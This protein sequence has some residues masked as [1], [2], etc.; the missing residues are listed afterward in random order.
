MIIRVET[1]ADVPTIRSVVTTAFLDAEHGSGNEAQII[2]ALREDGALSVSLVADDAVDVVGHAAFS[3]VVVGGRDINW[4][5]LGP[6]AVLPNKRRKGVAESLITA[7]LER[8]KK[9]GAEGCVVLGDPH[10]YRRFGFNS[11]PELCFADVPPEYFQRVVFTGQP[12]KGMVEY[13]PAF[14]VGT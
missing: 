10:Y 2:D 11:D 1:S 8:I 13:H 4:Y 14:F 5:G 7:G 3:P 9:L 6:V 12:P